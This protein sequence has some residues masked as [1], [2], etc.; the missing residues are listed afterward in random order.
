M[1]AIENI[2]RLRRSLPGL[3][4]CLT[5]CLLQL[6]CTYANTF[7]VSAADWDARACEK[8]EHEEY[9]KAIEDWD[10]ATRL[11]DSNPIYFWRRSRGCRKVGRIQQ[12]VDDAT[13]ALDLASPKDAR[14]R[15]FCLDTRAKA[16]IKLG[17]YEDAAKDF[18]EAIKLAEGKSDLAPIYMDRGEMHLELA[19]PKLALKDFSEAIK[20]VPTWGR[21]Y[22]F[23]A[24]A[25]DAL[26]DRAS[27]DKDRSTALQMNYDELSD[28]YEPLSIRSTI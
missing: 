9:D 16:L 11:D 5:L 28:R 25:H 2:L 21:A 10:Q 12:A 3:I 8:Y 1:R 19:E 15:M 6:G 14:R 23:R 4:A 27:A 26:E 24:K 22:F 18:D 20:L 7:P 17:K 13:H